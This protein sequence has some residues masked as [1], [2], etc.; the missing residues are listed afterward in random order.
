MYV[1][2]DAQL[3]IIYCLQLFKLKAWMQQ[4]MPWANWELNTISR[5]SFMH[6]LKAWNAKSTCIKT[7]LRQLCWKARHISKERNCQCSNFPAV[8]KIGYRSKHSSLQQGKQEQTLAASPT[9]W[10]CRFNVPGT[11]AAQ[12]FL[13][14]PD[15]WGSISNWGLTEDHAWRMRTAIKIA[16]EHAMPRGKYETCFPICIDWC[17]ICSKASPAFQRPGNSKRAY[18]LITYFGA[19]NGIELGEG[20]AE[21]AASLKDKKPWLLHAF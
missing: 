4:K 1:V 3:L 16:L 20:Y 13:F 9:A 15:R 17:V 14:D 8:D 5:G 2:E 21:I 19:R 10:L 7:V 18:R 12:I 11:N 6:L